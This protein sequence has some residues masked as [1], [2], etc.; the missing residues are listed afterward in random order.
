MQINKVQGD[1]KPFEP[2]SVDVRDCLVDD[3]INA[4]RITGKSTGFEFLAAVAASACVF[5]GQK[6]PPEDVKRLRSADFLDLSDALGLNGQVATS[7][8][9][10]SILSGKESGEK[11]E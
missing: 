10:S 8:D 1:Q 9:M 6:V 4:E 3:L 11:K 5:D 2:K 7:P